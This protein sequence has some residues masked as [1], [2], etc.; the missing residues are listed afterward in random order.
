[1]SDKQVTFAIIGLG[2]RGLSSYGEYIRNHPEGAKVVAVA[3][4]R[5]FFRNEAVRLHG[6][7]PEM[8][9]TSWEALLDQPRLADVLIIATTDR[10]HT[11]PAIRAAARGYHILLEKPMA[12]TAEEC[13]RIG[14]A[15]RKNK[16]LFAV[17][18][19]LRYAPFYVKVKEIIDS[20]ALGQIVTIQHLEGVGW[21]HQPHSFVR[22]NFGNESRSSFM[23][24]AKSCHDIDVIRWWVG[25]RCLNV[26]SFGDLKHFRKEGKPAGITATRC[27]DCPLGDE[28]CPYSAKKYYFGNLRQN[29]H[30]W[31]L[32]MV[33][34]EFTEPALEK[35]LREGP[36]G[37]C[38]YECDNDVVDHQVVIM[39]FEDRMTA[40]FTM[41]A[42]APH[43]RKTRIMGTKGYLEGDDHY[44]RVL[45]YNSQQWT[46]LEV[47][48]LATDIGGGHGGGDGRM[49]QALI[50]A[51]RTG[52]LEAVKTGLDV[53]LE[54]HLIVFAAE[55]ARREKRVVNMD[56]YLKSLKCL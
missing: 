43:G 55:L 14:E 16:V 52:T 13:L 32:A 17:C 28:G 23:L 21:W 20:G 8:I 9:F 19:V 22:G 53:S 49:M 47:N 6:V 33:I 40:D 29:H 46:E 35:A 41:T 44:I 3:E 54:S 38:V 48:K 51:V 26:A 27:M 37:R 12:P 7:R 15:V 25:K 45:D 36:Y 39:E 56:N 2:A 42:F 5:E 31:P 11:E 1:M 18:H 24:L 10:L 30:G 34:T 50:D 4:P